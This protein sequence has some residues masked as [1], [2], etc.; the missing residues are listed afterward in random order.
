MNVIGAVRFYV[1]RIINDISIRGMKVLILDDT[2][3][4]IVSMVLSQTEVLEHEIYL[5]ERLDRIKSKFDN[6]NFEEEKKEVPMQHMKAVVFVRPTEEN[7]NI[8]KQELR[9]PI[10]NEYHFFF[11]NIVKQEFL[12]ALAEADERCVVRQ[13]QEYYADIIPVNEDLFTLNQNGSLGFSLLRNNELTSSQNFQRTIDSILSI[14][15]AFKKTPSQIRYTASSQAAEQLA[16]EVISR[17]QNDS[18]FFFVGEGPMLLILD[19]KDDPVTPLLTQWTYQAMVHELLGLNNNRVVL[20]GAPGVHRDLEEVV[21]SCTQDQFFARSR[22]MNFGDL[23]L[24]V[25]ELLEDF[26]KQSKMNE[27]ISSI[28]DMQN[29]LERYPAFRSQSHNVSKHVAIISEL[30]RIVDRG[31]LMDVSQQ[32]QDLACN[33]DHATHF[34]ELKERIAANV[35]ESDKLKL[36]LLYALRYENQN[37]IETIKSKLLETGVSQE[38]VQLI[39]GLL[40]YAGERNRSPGLFDNKSF[41]GKMVKTFT[42]LQGV[43][44]I[45]AQHEP[46]LMSTLSNATKGKLKESLYPIAFGSN[47]NFRPTEIIV[48][49]IG[50]VTYEEATKVAEFNSSQQNNCRIILGGSYV[51]NSNSFLQE[52]RQFYSFNHRL[53]K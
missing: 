33:E 4:Q 15:L 20:R 17:T 8:L 40:N 31:S 37:Q 36:S 30:A 32:E 1:D 23:G 45:Y 7:L 35:Q 41:V 52:I 38:N 12:S 9:Q 3:T 50:G 21:L 22:N 16:Q 51:H 27:N 34:R 39:R 18:L 19:R 48:F 24:S 49:M 11:S 47:A 46:R 29:F 14:L 42:S 43:P 25:K 53:T 44:N 5:V 28:E 6:N 10:F 2:T 13:V 26:Q